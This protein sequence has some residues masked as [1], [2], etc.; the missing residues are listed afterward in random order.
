MV[1]ASMVILIGFLL[2][3]TIIELS[4]LFMRYVLLSETAATAARTVAVDNAGL[5]RRDWN[6]ALSP[7]STAAECHGQLNMYTRRVAENE[8]KKLFNHAPSSSGLA[9]EICCREISNAATAGASVILPIVKVSFALPFNCIVCNLL[10][11]T[12]NLSV[13]S[14]AIIEDECYNCQQGAFGFDGICSSADP[15]C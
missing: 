2:A 11:T 4:V 15:N 10:P 14:E 5:T 6:D 7:T 8:F 12:I 3:A 1:E 13:G 9:T